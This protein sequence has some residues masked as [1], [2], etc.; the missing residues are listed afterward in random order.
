M[1]R[2]LSLAQ[3][4]APPE[5]IPTH[6]SPSDVFGPSIIGEAG[7]NGNNITATTSNSSSINSSSGN[8]QSATKVF[9]DF[10][11]NV[12]GGEKGVTLA[13]AMA[14]VGGD[15]GG[16]A[17]THT[18]S[19]CTGEAAR[20]QRQQQQQQPRGGCREGFVAIEEVVD[21]PAK[22]HGTDNSGED[23]A[24]CSVVNAAAAA[25]VI[26][27]SAVD[28]DAQRSLHKIDGDGDVRLLSAQDVAPDLCFASSSSKASECESGGNSGGWVAVGKATDGNVDKRNEAGN[29]TASDMQRGDSVL[30]GTG[31]RVYIADA[32]SS[33]GDDIAAVA[34]G[35]RSDDLDPPI[36]RDTEVTNTDNN[37]DHDDVEKPLASNTNTTMVTPPTTPPEVS[38]EIIV[39]VLDH[40]AG[41][42][43]CLESSP[44]LQSG[45]QASNINHTGNT[46]FPPTSDE[47]TTTGATMAA[48]TMDAGPV[49]TAM[50]KGGIE[51]SVDA[52]A[53]ASTEFGRLGDCVTPA[54]MVSVV[55]DGMAA[56]V[57]EARAVSVRCS[58]VMG[59]RAQSSRDPMRTFIRPDHRP[60]SI[61]MDCRRG[62]GV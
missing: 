16:R 51:L 3:L 62:S 21:V 14:I 27:D 45:A 42:S 47:A 8:D 26:A 13:E 33:S 58:I 18:S 46:A 55:K 56:L 37:G 2:S 23:A 41:D 20:P 30:L 49:G 59:L 50:S 12:V 29:W 19:T 4:G 11:G 1:V 36:A 35:A 24:D 52:Y 43:T 48:V 38:S 32:R 44:L 28:A 39:P 57:E 61:D 15:G 6:I 40:P 60:Q 54:H 25:V 5:Y 53:N 7:R 22:L 31:T 9:G 10:D 17:H 34:A